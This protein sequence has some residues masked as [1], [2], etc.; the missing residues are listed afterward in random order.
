M[1]TSLRK[2]MKDRRRKQRQM[3]RQLATLAIIGGAALLLAI[4]ILPNLFKSS[5]PVGTFTVITPVPRPQAAGTAMGDSNALVRIDVF[6][7]FQCPAC[8][9]YSQQVEP[10]VVENYVAKGTVY[11]VFRQYPFI[12]NQSATR[13]SDQA[14][15]ASLCAADQGHF[16]DYH[17]MLYANWTGEN[18]GNFSNTRLTAFAESIGLDMTE[19][20]AC[21]KENRF[22]EQIDQD[23]KDGDIMGTSGTPSLFVNGKIVA[24]GQVPSYEEI[25]AAIEAELDQ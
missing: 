9:Y 4:I 19:F 18:I 10:Q 12:D 13:E 1:S 21:F 15:N 17:D 5:E 3:Q 6:E 16:W 24:P 22:K 2:D 8:Q 20:N 14:A 23:L 25:S 7:D 11:Y